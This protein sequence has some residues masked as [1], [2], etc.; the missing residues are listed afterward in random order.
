M[1]PRIGSRAGGD[2][3][4]LSVGCAPRPGR[5]RML[6]EELL[7]LYWM[8]E[9]AQAGVTRMGRN[10]EGGSIERREIA[11]SRRR[12]CAQLKLVFSHQPLQR[13]QAA[14]ACANRCRHS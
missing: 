12:R 11:R 13:T 7:A 9:S 14:P 4:H 1:T 5:D 3:P 8:D 10:A 2:A 6:L